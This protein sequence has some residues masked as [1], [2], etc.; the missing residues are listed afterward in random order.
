MRVSKN[1]AAPNR[2]GVL[3]GEN[4]KVRFRHEL[5]ELLPSIW[6]PRQA[7]MLATA[8]HQIPV[9]IANVRVFVLVWGIAEPLVTSTD[10]DALEMVATS[11]RLANAIAMWSHQKTGL[12]VDQ[13]VHGHGTGFAAHHEVVRCR[14]LRPQ[15]E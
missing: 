3:L 15:T 10:S 14:G 9:G 2:G 13:A 12:A 6:V 5:L 1:F 11:K 7:A 8:Q 4:V